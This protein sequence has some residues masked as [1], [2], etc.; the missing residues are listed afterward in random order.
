[1]RFAMLLLIA[2]CS[3]QAYAEGIFSTYVSSKGKGLSELR[4]KL[5]DDLEKR[6]ASVLDT[7]P[8]E[9]QKFHPPAAPDYT[10]TIAGVEY[11]G[12]MGGAWA[13]KDKNGK[14]TW[15]RSPEVAVFDKSLGGGSRGFQKD[16]TFQGKVVGLLEAAFKA[17]IG[18]HGLGK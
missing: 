11:W 17:K 16:N 2:L 6:I 14:W 12:H 9:L 1:M 15:V 5:P 4:V 13:F 18:K 8:K 10:L 3:A 7:A